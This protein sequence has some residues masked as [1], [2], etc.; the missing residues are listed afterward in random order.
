M[1]RKSINYS[2]KKVNVGIDVHKKVYSVYCS[3]EGQLVKKSTIP[4][5]P[6]NLVEFLKYHFSGADVCSVYEA[7]FSG[8][9]LHRVLVANGI[10]N[11][12]VNPSSIEVAAKDKV[13]TDKRDCKKMAIQ[14]EAGRLQGIHI[15]SIEQEHERLLTRTREQLVSERTRVSN[16]FKNRLYQFGLIPYNDET[17][18]SERFID[19]YLGINLPKRLHE[20]LAVLARLWKFVNLEIK[21]I[22]REMGQQAK[23]DKN[24]AIYRNVPGIGAISSRVLSNELGDMSQFR[25]ERAIFSHTGL[26]PCEFSSGGKQRLGHITHQGS[27]RLRCLLTEA[28]W[29]AIKEDAKLKEDFERIALKR[30]K[31]RAIVAIARKLIGRIRACFRKGESYQL[32][33]G[34]AA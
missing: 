4:A 8:F 23:Q 32:G 25:N 18:I 12:V 34:L 1:T 13:K 31:K 17:V 7:G 10:K 30:G 33:Y 28:S 19:N 16:Q 24:E 20:C 11:I 6:A 2:G 22:E 29:K 14:L 26:T 9:G 15:P 27:S 3:C 5:I 21:E